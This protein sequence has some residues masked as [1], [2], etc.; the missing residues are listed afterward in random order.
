MIQY[1]DTLLV[2]QLVTPIQNLAYALIKYITN[3][4]LLENTYCSIL[5]FVN[6]LTV[7]LTQ[8]VINHSYLGPWP[9]I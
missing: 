7:I 4:S 8:L 6:R 2:K 1:Y 5:S 9:Y 3:V